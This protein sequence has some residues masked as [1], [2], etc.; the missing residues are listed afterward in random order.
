MNQDPALHKA[1]VLLASLDADT[2]DLLLS[3]MPEEQADAVRAELLGLDELDPRE[4]QAVIDEFFR[5]GPMAPESSD[6]NAPHQH[7]HSPEHSRR[8]PDSLDEYLSEHSPSLGHS[9]S[10]SD[11]LSSLQP[12]AHPAGE[13]F[14]DFLQDAEPET[15]VP[16]LEREHPQAIALVL[17][18]LPHERAGHILARLPATLQTDVIRRLVD[19]EETDPHVLRD[20]ERAVESG[21][22]QRQ[23]TRRR[24]AGMA[25]VSAILNASEGS[26]RRQILNNLAAHDRPLA[27][28]LTPPPSPPRDFTFEQVCDFPMEA[29]VRVV[30]AADRRC[31]VLALAGAPAEIVEPLLQELRPEEA[32][33][34]SHGLEQLGPLRIIDFDRAQAAIAELAGHLYAQG[35]LSGLEAS[36]LTATA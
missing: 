17:A 1:A 34:I 10:L 11:S 7:L 6:I 2:A 25:A 23:P 21:L 24:M 16:V 32:D 20:V 29:F 36:H 5:I 28:K 4:Q 22:R 14:F 30:R 18:H 8:L 13:R 26:A 19:L 35:H 12:T 27:H 15:L 31:A 9:E 33:S 3:Q